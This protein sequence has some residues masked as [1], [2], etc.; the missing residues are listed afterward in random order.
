MT[1]SRGTTEVLTR[2]CGWAAGQ[3]NPWASNGRWVGWWM[4]PVAPGCSTWRWTLGCVHRSPGTGRGSERG[5][6]PCGGV[7]WVAPNHGWLISPTQRGK[8]IYPLRWRLTS[9][10][11]RSVANKTYPT[12]DI[13]KV[14]QEGSDLGV[15]LKVQQSDLR[16]TKNMRSKTLLS[17]T[18]YLQ[19]LHGYT[20]IR[21]GS[22][23]RTA[24]VTCW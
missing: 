4:Q 3:R 9:D 16:K 7:C 20:F 18:E 13:Y 23:P 10:P 5:F 1:R 8:C 12:D 11:P 22:S 2:I 19:A 17:A 24:R 15:W 6:S 14:G 21:W